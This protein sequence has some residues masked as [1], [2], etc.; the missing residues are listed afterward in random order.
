MDGGGGR[1][2]T[3]EGFADRF[4]VCSLWPLG[5]P[6]IQKTPGGFRP[7]PRRARAVPRT[8]APHQEHRDQS[9]AGEGT[10]TPNHLITNEMLY[11]LSYASGSGTRPALR[12]AP[13][14]VIGRLGEAPDVLEHG[15][16]LVIAEHLAPRRHRALAVADHLQQLV[17]GARVHVAAV[18]VVPGLRI[19]SGRSG[20][21]PFSVRAVAEHAALGVDL[22]TQVTS[23]RGSGAGARRGVLR[24]RLRGGW[25]RGLTRLLLRIPSTSCNESVSNRREHEKRRECCK[26]ARPGGAYLHG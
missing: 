3:S 20:S 7:Q 16:D 6:S 2:R 12:L 19:Q 15:V 5:N 23:R 1:I 24:R 25:G 26:R 11:Q 9:L 17:V 22:G 8:L 4:T 14:P 18:G 10:R 13:T 21:I